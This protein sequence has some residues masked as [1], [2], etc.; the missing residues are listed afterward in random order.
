VAYQ[1]K[2]QIKTS[3]L[4]QLNKINASVDR[5][6]KSIISINKGGIK[7]KENVTAG[8]QQLQQSKQQLVAK[9]QTNKE[10]TGILQKQ[11]GIT[12]ELKQQATSATKISKANKTIGTSGGSSTGSKA[13]GK[14]GVLSSALISGSFP[15]LFGQGLPGALAG[16]LGGGIGA[17]VGGQMGG[18]AGGLVA[19]SLLT[20][21]QGT[22]EKLNTLGDALNDPSKNIQELASRISFF[23]KSV[24]TT[25]ETLKSGG[26][27]RV[28]GDLAR[29]TLE[30]RVGPEQLKPIKVLNKE[31][32]KFAMLSRDLGM[33][34]SSMVAGPL[35]AFFKVMNLTMG[36]SGAKS[37]SN[38]L[39][40]QESI[41]EAEKKLE[42]S[43]PALKTAKDEVRLL[44]EQLQ[45]N[46]KIVDITRERLKAGEKLTFEERKVARN[47]QSSVTILKNRNRIARENLEIAEKEVGNGERLIEIFKLEKQILASQ[48]NELKDQLKLQ[49]VKTSI[50]RGVTDEKSLAIAQKK[51]EIAKV[52]RKIEK[53][54][55]QLAVILRDGT[56]REQDAQKT[57]IANLELEKQL[58]TDIANERIRAADPM[59]S[60]VDE[61][62]RELLKLNTIQVQSVELSKTIGTTFEESF[63]GVIRGTTSVEQAFGNMLNRI[64]DHFLNL[65]AKLMANKLQAGILGL[66]TKSVGGGLF[67]GGGGSGVEFG[68]VDLGIS[69]GLGF[70]NGG[71]PPVGR[72]S[73]VGEKG[74]E[75]FVPK[76]SGTIVPNNKLG[77]GGSTSVV[78]N[79]DASGSDVQGD[80]AGAKEL[81]TL[82][83]VAVQ[84]ELIKQQR[85]GGL[86]ASVR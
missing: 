22:A 80:D 34:I 78:V 44:E 76:S 63:K 67:S 75:L 64:A 5:I 35:T 46:Q 16:G 84:G 20:I 33:K 25:I 49:S 41:R 38:D 11:T 71:R 31:M 43:L 58:I 15:L 29:I 61:L 55:A 70:A 30:N 26:L 37:G 36:G 32:E 51:V 6:N 17:A 10:L 47:A 2:I 59:L 1:A 52:E 4:S 8:K 57:K 7:G 86:L 40:V 54:K 13:G 48:T 73:L 53:E 19:T 65:A 81:G 82:I 60:R 72:A 3:G 39:S 28:A 42:T 18:F 56:K 24:G 77:G 50:T 12:K 69:S 74:P 14:G 23:D 45:K 66:L 85:P 62:N 9:K 68:S 79:V 27:D 21:F 83:S